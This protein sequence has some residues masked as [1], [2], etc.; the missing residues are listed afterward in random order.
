[1][2]FLEEAS[3]LQYR[4]QNRR[5]LKLAFDVLQGAGRAVSQMATTPC[6]S[7]YRF[8]F[9]LAF[10]NNATQVLLQFFF[11]ICSLSTDQC[12][13]S[14]GSLPPQAALKQLP[15]NRV[16]SMAV[17]LKSLTRANVDAGAVFK[18]S[19]GKGD[20]GNVAKRPFPAT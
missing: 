7:L 16:P 15:K 8:L 13:S 12:L 14:A 5:F 19:T 18:D 11:L 2:T 6:S 17:V 1:M 20:W 4:K 9:F 10:E 3:S